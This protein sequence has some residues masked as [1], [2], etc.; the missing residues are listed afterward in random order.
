MS[1]AQESSI[2]T[3]ATKNSGTD[4]S[5]AAASYGNTENAIGDYT[6]NLAQFTSGNPYTKGGEYD[7]TINTGLANASDAGANSLAGSL[8]SQALRTGQNS[9]ASLATAK[10]GA[11]QNTR[12]LSSSLAS[13]DQARIGS[14]AGYNQTALGASSVPINAQSS[15]YGTSLSGG[16]SALNTAADAAKTPGFWDEVGNSFAG[17][18]GRLNVGN[19]GQVSLGQQQG[20]WVAAELYGGWHDPRVHALRAWIFG[21]YSKTFWGNIWAGLYSKYGREA[22]DLVRRYSVVRKIAQHVFDKALVRAQEWRG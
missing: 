18:L 8:Q 19:Q 17:D 5:N 12:D 10:S 14:E 21:P 2:D 9:A 1:R 3:T 4:Q 22:A 7:Q 13:A 15:L 6:K 16:N 20:C 11:Q